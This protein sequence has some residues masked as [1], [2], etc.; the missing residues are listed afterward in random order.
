MKEHVMQLS[1]VKKGID[2]VEQ[3]ADASKR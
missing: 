2:R 3:C 1:E